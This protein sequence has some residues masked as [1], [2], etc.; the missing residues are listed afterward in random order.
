MKLAH[1]PILDRVRRFISVASRLHYLTLLMLSA[2]LFGGLQAASAQ[3]TTVAYVLHHGNDKLYAY[4]LQP[5]G[6]PTRIG[7]PL[8]TPFR[9]PRG[10]AIDRKANFVFVGS[11]DH[12]IAIYRVRHSGALIY[13][14][15]VHT[16]KNPSQLATDPKGPFLYAATTF[17]YIYEFRITRHGTLAALPLIKLNHSVDYIA[18]NPAGTLAYVVTG[19]GNDV[20]P[21]YIYVYKIQTDG[22]LHYVEHVES[23]KY[24]TLWRAY[25]DPTGHYLY[26]NDFWFHC[27][28][29]YHINTDG[30]IERL[31]KLVRMGSLMGF[32]P[33]GHIAYLLKEGQFSHN[34]KIASYKVDTN[35]ALTLIGHPSGEVIAP[36]IYDFAFDPSLHVAIVASDT[37]IGIY[38]VNKDGVIMSQGQ[39]YD[40]RW[41]ALSHE[42]LLV[43][44]HLKAP[45]L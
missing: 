4:R 28:V 17:G 9:Q 10:L 21:R 31:H 27:V 5:N 6:I 30:T 42:S 16:S 14:G 13:S 18:I 35:G 38:H 11:W 29:T 24:D 1:R 39:F 12:G 25:V 41:N 34:R 23:K 33:K 8:Q 36:H 20:N 45:G 19:F 7:P 32:S 43:L 15:L 3:D 22:Q 44:G 2:F 37:A 26:V 40:A